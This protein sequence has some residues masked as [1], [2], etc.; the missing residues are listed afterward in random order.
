MT[1]PS[2]SDYIIFVDESGDHRLDSINPEY[3]VFVLNFCVFE[4][5]E[6]IDV[7]CPA[8]QKFKFLH[9]GHD[10]VIL[11]EH[12][13]GKQKPPFV[14]LKS[15][16]PRTTFISDLTEIISGTK[17]TLISAAID[18]KRLIKKYA[19][20]ASPYDLAM[21]FC[22]ERT[23][24]FLKDHGQADRITHIIVEQRGRKEDSELELEFRRVCDGANFRTEK[25]TEFELLFADKKAN[26]AGLQFAD[27]TARPI[28]RHVIDPT[29]PNRAY[30][31][32]A[33]KFR[34]N[35]DGKIDG[36][37]LKVFP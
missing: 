29:Q 27:L 16:T 34:C 15:E 17:F 2:F 4:K 35:A 23:H 25:F 22:L 28:G 6:Y 13:I 5:R 33:K 32:L 30:S 31:I 36:W 26:L 37:G 10:H 12:E 14:F 19:V 11:H 3:P 9:F 8:L 1:A 7:V 18:K 24:A 20:P 21:R